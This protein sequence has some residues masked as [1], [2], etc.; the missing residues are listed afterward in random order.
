MILS[1]RSGGSVPPELGKWS[2]VVMARAACMW[3]PENVAELCLQVEQHSQ[4]E[5]E[6]A[7]R[8]GT[9][10]QRQAE[11]LEFQASLVYLC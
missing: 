1:P 4:F 5:G 11:L 6:I 7:G 8:G 2:P 10:K 3:L 9:G